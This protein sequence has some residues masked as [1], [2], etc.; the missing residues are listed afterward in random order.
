MPTEAE[1]LTTADR[2]VPDETRRQWEA[3]RIE[4]GMADIRAGRTVSWEAVRAWMMSWDTP[5]PLP[6][7][8]RED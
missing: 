1:H 2:N 5:T 6:K 4:E 7:S 3:D 8:G